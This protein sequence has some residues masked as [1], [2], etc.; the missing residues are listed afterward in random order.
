MNEELMYKKGSEK[1]L[2]TL[3][4]SR[5]NA[6]KF[7]SLN[8]GIYL[9]TKEAFSLYEIIETNTSKRKPLW[10]N[11][12][13]IETVVSALILIS[14]KLT[15]ESDVKW[16][17]HLLIEKIANEFFEGDMK[18]G[19]GF[20][21]WIIENS[22]LFE[23]TITQKGIQKIVNYILNP[24]VTEDIIAQVNAR[25]AREFYPLPMTEKPIQWHYEEEKAIGGYKTKQFPIVRGVKNPSKLNDHL[26]RSINTLQAVP[27]RINTVALEA[28]K[29]NLVEP[30]KSDFVKVDFP[31]KSDKKWTADEIDLIKLY[32][33]Q[34]KAYKSELGKYRANVLM[35]DIA[36][37]Y[38]NEE[39]IYFPWNFDYRGRKYPIAVFLNPQGDDAVKAILEF[40]DGITL[41]DA[42]IS[43]MYYTLAGLWGADKEEPEERIIIGKEVVSNN[44]LEADEPYQF[45]ALQT[46]VKEWQSDNSALIYTP[47]HLDGCANGSQHTAMLTGCKSTAYATNIL[48]SPDGKRRD[49]Y[50]EVADK[51]LEL[52]RISD[53]LQDVIAYI[54]D[55]LE[56]NGRKYAKNPTMTKVYSAKLQSFAQSCLKNMHDLNYIIDLCNE[57]TAF[58]FAKEIAKA[59]DVI[60]KGGTIWEKWIQAT[61]KILTSNNKGFSWVTPDGFKVVVDRKKRKSK[62]LKIKLNGKTILLSV[63]ENTPDIDSNKIKSGISPN[64]IHSFDATH[65]RMTE[66]KCL[67]FGITQFNMIHDSFG[68]DMNNL[69]NLLRFTKEAWVEMYGNFDIAENLANQFRTQT[70]KEIESC[71]FLG[72]FNVEEVYKSNHFF[73]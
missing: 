12:I 25:A 68:C 61:S 55:C 22:E 52:V 33:S 42:G 38:K 57:K 14:S 39:R 73:S 69:W 16:K 4:N 2:N 13:T 46:K 6:K 50:I 45:L 71:S 23:K 63:N 65:L 20:T 35:L 9:I 49:L 44:Y 58:A 36:D 27:Y 26:L 51:A 41:N 1:V 60:L 66:S 29:A 10:Y 56:S 28:V 59:L 40:A 8:T 62:V 21:E 53:N 54:V 72:G 31:E 30:K 11:F 18:L 48:P 64:V 3:T 70:D 37:Q 19:L 24:V 15:I 7:S 43:A 17:R 5:G 32:K 47:S 34:I 67:D